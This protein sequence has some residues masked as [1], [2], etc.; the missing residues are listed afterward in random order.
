MEPHLQ[1]FSPIFSLIKPRGGWSLSDSIMILVA[2]ALVGFAAF[3]AYAETA[4]VR[5]SK[6]R[7]L[8]LQEKGV[9]GSE[10]LLDL[11]ADPPKFLNPILLLTLICQLVAAT[12]VGVVAAARFGGFGVLAGTVFEVVVIFILGEALP[13]NI[14]V[15]KPD[16]AAIRS[17]K[18]VQFLVKFPPVA[19]VSSLVIGLARLLIPGE[20]DPYGTVSE[21]ELLAMADAALEGEVIE[22]EERELIHSVIN[23]GDTVARE[24]MVPR[25]DVVSASISQSVSEVVDLILEAGISR[26]PVYSGSLDNVVGIVF[27]KDLLRAERDGERDMTIEPLIRPAHFV[28][29]TKPVAELLRDMQ[30][31]KFHMAI[32]IDEYGS[33][34][35]LVTLEDLL[36]ELVG[37]ITDEY[38][39][40]VQEVLEIAPG[41]WEVSGSMSVDDLS[42]LLDVDLPEGDWDTVGGMLLGLLGHLPVGG[43]EVETS[44]FLFRADQVTSRR[45]EKVHVARVDETVESS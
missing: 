29:E 41:E 27:A 3:L 14:S 26:V 21:E 31:G 7:A 24:V 10:R 28:P 9:P 18:V 39:N 12:L 1:L 45:V 19:L 43:E 40:E 20:F 42:E 6:I 37:D 2:I 36:E 15:R 35:G 38:D 44:G 17:A 8:A 4:L 13:K 22:D 32:I 23:F 25:P 11:M 34:V 30:N 5:M 16:K 33:T